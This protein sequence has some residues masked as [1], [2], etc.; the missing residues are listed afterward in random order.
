MGEIEEDNFPRGGTRPPQSLKRPNKEENLFSQTTKPKPKKQKKEKKKPEGTLNEDAFHSSL[1]IQGTLSYNS[2]R[3]DMLILG[4][5]RHITNFSLEIELP[6]LTFGH[7]NITNISDSLTKYL[8]HKLEQADEDNDTF[9]TKMFTVGQYVLTKVL[10]IENRDKGIHVECTLNPREIYSDKL[11]NSFEKGMLVWAAVQSELEH[12]YELSAGIKNCRIFLPFKNTDE[13]RKL[14]T[15][16]L[17]WCV[18]HKCEISNAASTLRVG[19]KTQHLKNAKIEEIDNLYKLIP[20]MQVEVVVDKITASGLQCKF[21][22][23]FFGYIDEGFLMKD[24]SKYQEG[25]ILN[26]HVLYVDHAVKITYFTT[27]DI[28]VIHAPDYNI[29]EV[30][31]AEVVS[32]APNGVYFKL[33]SKSLCLVTNRRLINSL[34]KKYANLDFSETIRLK[35]APNTR[36]QCRILDYNRLSKLYIGTVEQTVIKESVFNSNDLAVG[37]LVNATIKDIKQEGL[38]ISTGQVTGFVSNLYVSNVAYSDPIKKKFREGQN[39]KARVLDVKDDNVLFTLKTGQVDSDA[40]L[41]DINQAKRGETYPGVVVQTKPGGAMIAFYGNAKGWLSKKFLNAEEDNKPDP[42]LLFYIG[43]VINPWILGVKND[44][45]ILS[46]SEPRKRKEFE[47]IPVGRKVSGIISG[48]KKDRIFVKSKK[49]ESIGSVHA[50]HLCSTV[51]LCSTMLKTYKVGDKMHDLLCVSKSEGRNWLSLREASALKRHQHIRLQKFSTLKP[52]FVVRCSYLSTCN[53]GIYV[54]PLILDYS[55]KILIKKRDIIASGKLPSFAPQQSIVTKIV[56]ITQKPQQIRLTAKLN[57]V[58]SSSVDDSI[59]YFKEYLTS[60]QRIRNFGMEHNW[61]ICAYKPGERIVC[62]VEKLGEKGGCLVKLPNGVNGLVAPRLCPDKL[63]EG[64][65]V[66]G[67]FLSQ[68]FTKNYAEVCLKPDIYQKIN[69][70]QDGTISSL[71]I[72]TCIAET[73]LIG[74]DSILALLKQKDGNR[75]LVYAPTNLHENDFEGCSKH[76]QQDKIKLRICGKADT[77]VIGMNKKLY[78]ALEK[79]ESKLE[80]IEKRRLVKKYTNEN[81]I[82]I[83]EEDT[84]QDEDVDDESE[85]MEVQSEE[86]SADEETE[87]MEEQCDDIKSEDD[88]EDDEDITETYLQV[89]NNISDKDR[90][91]VLSGVSSFFNVA[92]NDQADVSSDEELEETT[93]TKKKKLS[94]AERLQQAKEEEERISKI[95]KELADASKSPE[96]AEQFDRLLLANPNSSELWTKYIAFHT[97]A[98]EFDKARVVAKRALEA[99]NM[100]LVDERFNIWI[101][102]LNLENMLGTKESFDKTFEEAVKYNDSLKIYLQAVKMLAESGK[103]ADMEEK[104]KKARNK[105]KQVPEM[106]LEIAK[107]YYEL[108]QFK[109]ARNIKDAALKSIDNKKSQLEIIV[110]FAIMEFKLGDP[111]HG[112]AIFETI[113]SSDPKKVTVWTTY[114]DQLVKK[115]NIEQARQVLERSVCH[116][117]PLKSM[118]TLFM[119]YRMFEEQHGTEQSVE[120]V[121]EK[122]KEYVSKVT[123]K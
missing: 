48:I 35:F 91:P 123:L 67:V 97:A 103:L 58:F 86:E 30:V 87:P 34:P 92:S 111:D 93:V 101:A 6:G 1:K 107:T 82:Q 4:C 106:W 89:D 88:S 20:G 27:F 18:I 80:Q 50:N 12:G 118:K 104:I 72:A 102:L 19:N 57:D 99:I 14:F 120:L 45:A 21:L 52:G 70:L 2:L 11:H 63:K 114:V 39:I 22:D 98:T 69:P 53:S 59:K 26:A 66:T 7:V 109:D 44:A 115:N 33:P 51:S 10:N 100:T 110:K 31:K 60:L 17:L 105:Y 41:T 94:A 79:N 90:M 95:E 13:T 117:L 65:N 24:L 15:G 56:E 49:G 40:C 96:N 9:L 38:I 36:H 85:A 42:R 81:T 8:N 116:R 84:N 112:A 71:N 64:E 121:K 43:Q 37:Q 32:K 122:A 73:L 5:I 28:D 23:N 25:N 3:T 16:E 68:N 108:G 119:K 75:Q 46:L 77:L 74:N 76:Y 47:D 78:A 113:L 62:K 29:G 83:E 55:E 54:M 61:D